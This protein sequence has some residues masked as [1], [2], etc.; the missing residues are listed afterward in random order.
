MPN[1]F[2]SI[3]KIY[4]AFFMAT[5]FS[6]QCFA[7][8]EA[9][10]QLLQRIENSKQSLKPPFVVARIAGLSLEEASEQVLAFENEKPKLKPWPSK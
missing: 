8:D 4:I 2:T 5:L 10:S 9:A 7:N 1:I 3:H 6:H